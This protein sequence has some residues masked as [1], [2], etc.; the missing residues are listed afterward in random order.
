MGELNRAGLNK[1]SLVTTG[2]SEQAPMNIDRAERT[3]FGVSAGGH[4]PAVR[5]TVRWL[6]RHPPAAAA[7]APADRGS[8][9]RR[10][11]A[12]KR[13]AADLAAKPPAPKLAEIEGPVEPAPPPPLAQEEPAPLPRQAAPAPSPTPKPAKRQETP[14]PAKASSAKSTSAETS[15]NRPTGRL[16]G[17]LKGMADNDFDSRSTAPP[18][19]RISSAVQSSLAGAIRSQIIPHWRGPSGPDVDQLKT[20]LRI[21]L[22]RDGSVTNVTG[23]TP[24]VSTQTTGLRPNCTGNGPS[25]PCGLRRHSL[26]PR[27]SMR[28]GSPLM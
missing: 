21:N 15:P 4:D 2:G 20:V 5:L 16:K 27:N 24:P 26:C 7:Q 3:G 23:S 18:A 19:A 14:A 28:G 10:D 12:R 11:R 13:R 1:V 9:G 6:P 22:A 17:L 25:R 8:T